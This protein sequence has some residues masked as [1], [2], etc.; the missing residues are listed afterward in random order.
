[1]DVRNSIVSGGFLDAFSLKIYVRITHSIMLSFELCSRH[2]ATHSKGNHEAHTGHGGDGVPGRHTR[3]LRL[4]VLVDF[5]QWRPFDLLEGGGRVRSVVVVI[6]GVTAPWT[7]A[8]P[9]AP[10]HLLIAAVTAMVAL[11]DLELL[12]GRF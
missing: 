9:L 10:L 7:T 12:H 5:P 3:T 4:A 1:M 2:V 11:R 6:V 8:L